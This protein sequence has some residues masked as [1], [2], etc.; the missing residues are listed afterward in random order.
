MSNVRA[1][2]HSTLCKQIREAREHYYRDPGSCT[3]S[4]AEY[5]KIERIVIALELEDPSLIN[6]LSPNSYIE[7][8]MEYNK[9]LQMTGQEATQFAITVAEC[10]ETYQEATETYEAI[11]KPSK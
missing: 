3:L 9:Y 11:K 2:L 1:A 6:R 4:D 10:N 8:P 7:V 5:D